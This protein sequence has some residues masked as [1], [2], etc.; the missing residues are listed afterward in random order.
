MS[1]H[2]A[3]EQHLE[4][5]LELARAGVGLASP[6]PYVGAVIAD[7]HGNVVGSGTYTY[8]GVKHAEI[9]ALEQAGTKA[10]G[11]TL[12]INLEPHAHQG[13]T[14][15]CTDA[16]I[17]AGIRRVLASMADPNPKVSGRGFEQLRAAGVQVEVGGLEEQARSLNEAFARYARHGTPLVT[18]KAAMTLDGKIAPPPTETL[19]RGSGTPAGG[20][21]TNEVARAHVQELRHQNDALMVGVGTILSD[22]PLL[23]DRSGKPRRRPL[24]RVILDSRLRLP[25][26]SRLVKSVAGE[27]ANDVLVFCSS[28]EEQKKAELEKLGVRVETIA[29]I[30]EDGR[31]DLPAILR[32]LG[33]L[34]ITSL[35]IEG[36]ATVNWAALA[37]NVVD[38]VFLYYA[39]KILAGTGSVPFAAGAE[40]RHMSEAAQVK[41]LHLH[42]FGEDF[43][44][45]GYVRDPYGE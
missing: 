15:P 3:D 38:K 20:W 10:R 9:L 13:R 17:T 11:G 5:A 41:H 39:P 26:D 33:E 31:P 19:F 42:R 7:S 30:E 28:A 40:F 21:V 36:G 45:E 8:D 4:R 2:S 12:Y 35:M 43:A 44:V 23:T 6:N 27:R 32:R 37:A 24:L 25:L 34:E 1:A 16:L 18:L 22:N 29:P 14:P